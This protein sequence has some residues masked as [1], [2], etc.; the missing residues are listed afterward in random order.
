MAIGKEQS[1]CRHTH[2]GTERAE[3][4]REQDERGKSCPLTPHTHP[5]VVPCVVPLVPCVVPLVPRFII[6]PSCLKGEGLSLV[7]EITFGGSISGP[8]HTPKGSGATYEISDF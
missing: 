2:G 6:R 3:S 5:I 4:I 1:S 8:F 7:R